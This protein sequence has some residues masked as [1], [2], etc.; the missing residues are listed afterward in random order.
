MIDRQRVSIG[1]KRSPDHAAQRHR[2]IAGYFAPGIDAAIGLSRLTEKHL[3]APSSAER[4]TTGAALASIAVLR[5]GVPVMR[6]AP[7]L[8]P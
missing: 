7:A 2:G 6:G 3:H 5:W 1:A 8:Q 4:M